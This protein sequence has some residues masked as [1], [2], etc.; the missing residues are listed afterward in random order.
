MQAT[1]GHLYNFSLCSSVVPLKGPF[2]SLP[3]RRVALALSGC[4]DLWC[5]FCGSSILSPPPSYTFWT[6]LPFKCIR[7]YPYRSFHIVYD[8]SFVWHKCAIVPTIEREVRTE[9]V[10]PKQRPTQSRKGLHHQ[11]GCNATETP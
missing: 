9:S 3:D 2:G 8:L 10:H 11:K 7:S 5:V 6:S 4:S 1:L